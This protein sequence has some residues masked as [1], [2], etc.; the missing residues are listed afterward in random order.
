ML[1]SLFRQPVRMWRNWYTR[2]LEV[3]VGNALASSS[4]A[5][6]IF[7]CLYS[8]ANGQK[9]LDR[10]LLF[11]GMGN[12]ESG[13]GNGEWGIGSRES[14]GDEGDMTNDKCPMPNDKCPTP[15]LIAIFLCFYRNR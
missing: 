1:Y 7:W 9:I 13:M 15:Y 6:R 3:R 2:T 4:L 5:I 14:G 8:R 11:Y 12:G 10:W